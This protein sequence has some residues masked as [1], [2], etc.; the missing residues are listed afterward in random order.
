[1]VAFATW[2]RLWTQPIAK[3][4]NTL[5]EFNILE[6]VFSRVGFLGFSAEIVANRHQYVH[7]FNINYYGRRI[8]DNVSTPGFGLYDTLKVGN[9][10][11]FAHQNYNNKVPSKQ[12]VNH[13]GRYHSDQIGIYGELYG[14]FALYSLPLFLIGSYFAGRIYFSPNASSSDFR[15]A[16]QRTMIL[17]FCSRIF[18]S[19]GL[20][21]SVTEFWPYLV[22]S[23]IL[24]IIFKSKVIA[25]NSSQNVKRKDTLSGL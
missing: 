6:H 13:G 23:G 5:P 14:F 1:M 17:Y 16:L 18:N 10:L 2:H 25:N 9:A 7:I 4:T 19:F 3:P 15:G 24:Y 12:F 21:W 11:V 20:D 22:S 8:V